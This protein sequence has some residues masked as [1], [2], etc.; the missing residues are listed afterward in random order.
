[1]MDGVTDEKQTYVGESGVCAGG[2]YVLTATERT[3]VTD[4]VS[5]AVGGDAEALLL[6]IVVVDDVLPDVCLV[7]EYRYDDET[8][9]RHDEREIRGGQS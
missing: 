9:K 6:L 7:A 3:Q 1:M 5:L 2:V 8:D 4:S